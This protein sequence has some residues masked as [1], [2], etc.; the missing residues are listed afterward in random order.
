M[1][2]RLKKP[3]GMGRRAR[4]MDDRAVT[5]NRSL[6]DD[7]RREDFRSLMRQEVLPRL[8]PIPGYHVM[9]ATTQN[10]RDPI[11][12]RLQAGYEVVRAEDIPGWESLSVKT[13]EYAGAIGVNEMIAL[14]CP[15]SLYREMMTYFHH[16]LPNQ[17]QER[18]DSML[19]ELRN[20]A[21]ARGLKVTEGDELERTP[22]F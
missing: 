9:W 21:A 12:R 10:A 16:D 18:R 11:M 2:E 20:Q 1:D 15:E 8:P 6:T 3:V 13:G 19:D 14:K 17:E 5:E 4:A 7:V 22:E